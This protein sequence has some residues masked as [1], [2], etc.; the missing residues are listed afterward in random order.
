MRF[1]QACWLVKVK[2]GARGD[3]LIVNTAPVGFV[4]CELNTSNH[5]S[6]ITTKSRTK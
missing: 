1:A 4:T 5:I 3:D 2:V 6:T